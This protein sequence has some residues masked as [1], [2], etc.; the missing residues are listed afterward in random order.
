MNSQNITITEEYNVRGTNEVWDSCI[1]GLKTMEEAI[2]ASKVFSLENGEGFTTHIYRH[3]TMT[4][5]D[6][7]MN[8]TTHEYGVTRAGEVKTIRIFREDDE[9]IDEMKNELIRVATPFTE[10]E[11]NEYKNK[12]KE[13]EK[14]IDVIIHLTRCSRKSGFRFIYFDDRNYND[15][16]VSLIGSMMWR[17]GI[18]ED[19]DRILKHFN[20]Q[21]TALVKKFTEE[22]PVRKLS[23]EVRT[24]LKGCEPVLLG[25]W[26]EISG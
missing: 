19:D 12:F 2:E 5:D 20:E 23:K 17:R 11:E 10:D 16:V 4:R 14:D 13:V 6:D 9:L 18:R 24:T 7:A 21:I 3:I 22:C 8:A 25:A 1:T 26:Y 15:S